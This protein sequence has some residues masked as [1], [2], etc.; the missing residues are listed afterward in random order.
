MIPM[1][2]NP[3]MKLAIPST[4]KMVAGTNRHRDVRG[5]VGFVSARGAAYGFGSMNDIAS[6]S[7]DVT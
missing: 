5:G 4:K 3:N 6:C 1:A 7:I 2:T